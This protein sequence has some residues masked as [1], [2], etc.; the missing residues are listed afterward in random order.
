MATESRVKKTLLNVRVN[1]I[2][3]FLTLI[4]SFF[5]RKVFL[6]CLGDNFVGLTSTLQNLLGFLNLA[7]L[8]VGSAIAY[9]LYQPLFERDEEKINE[10]ISVLG[11]LYRWIGCI[12]LGGGLILS[13]FLPLIFPDSDTGLS[14]GLIYF[15]F[16]SFLFSSLIGYFINFKQ[17]LLAAD[18]RNYVVMAYYQSG[19]IVKTILQIIVA[20]Y[21]GNMYLWVLLELINGI[22]Y[23]IVLNKKIAQTYPWL[24]SKIKDGK[25]LLKKYPAIPTKTKQLFVHKI[26]YFVQVQTIPFLT[27]SFV[28]LQMVAFYTNYAM[29]A[30]KLD[31]LM[32]QVMN[33]VSAGIGNLIAE[34]NKTV[35]LRTYWELSSIRLVCLTLFCYVIY[36]FIPGFIIL[37][38]GEEYVL[39]PLILE[40]VTIN[41]CLGCISPTTD[42]FLYGYGLFQDIWA[43]ITEVV[44]FFTTAIIGGFYLGLPGI[45]LG[46]T[47]SMG[48]IRVFWKPYF[49]FSRGFKMSTWK[50]W[51]RWFKLFALALLS[52]F[53]SNH[54]SV[55]LFDLTKN[56]NWGLFIAKVV[57]GTSILIVV[58]LAL[59]GL[60]SSEFR[61]AVNRFR[62]LIVRKMA[63]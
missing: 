52:F 47:V 8:G 38:I 36:T 31:N 28:S 40:L 4:L 48:I 41:L 6:N 54:I 7:E 25:F 59:F 20:Y 46:S 27:Y 57:G 19:I 56:A 24:K 32:G 26:A 17:N 3:Y 29:L 11:F 35:I 63:S 42:H 13:C 49:L 9:V 51:P 18:Q 30:T 1:L 12:V 10:I 43:P 14:L 44:I 33:S 45:L 60:F 58:S 37:W 55:S 53:I 16:Y 34:G 23:S 22:I 62:N 39:P 21:T 5:S 15:A 50:Y 2:F 61:L